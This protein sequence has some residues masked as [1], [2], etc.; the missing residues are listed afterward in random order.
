[1]TISVLVDGD[2]IPAWI[3]SGSYHL[4]QSVEPVNGG[5]DGTGEASYGHI[6]GQF[7]GLVDGSEWS[8]HVVAIEQDQEFKILTIDF[9]PMGA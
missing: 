8:L 9:Q 2:Y 6:Q 3:G 5:Y 4:T 1:M 7:I